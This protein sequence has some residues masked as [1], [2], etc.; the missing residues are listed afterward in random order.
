MGKIAGK[1]NDL[2][3]INP[4]LLQIIQDII[5]FIQLLFHKKFKII[6]I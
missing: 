6:R 3:Q 5:P 2:R 1:H 4:I